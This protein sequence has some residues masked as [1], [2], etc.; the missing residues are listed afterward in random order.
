MAELRFIGRGCFAL[1]SGAAD[2]AEGGAELVDAPLWNSRDT[3]GRDGG[4]SSDAIVVRETRLSNRWYGAG[5]FRV[6]GCQSPWE[7]TADA[8]IAR[9]GRQ[10]DPFSSCG[11]GEATSEGE[12]EKTRIR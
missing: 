9:S 8:V 11:G 1:R 10:R 7:P 4:L 3:P 5:L 12:R 2:A 6:E